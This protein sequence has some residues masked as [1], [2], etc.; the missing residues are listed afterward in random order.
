MVVMTACGPT[1]GDI[2]LPG[3]G[4]TGET[5]VAKAAFDD[6]LNLSQG[7]IVRI[8]GVASGRVQTVRVDDFRAIV[9]MKLHKEAQ[10][11][12][13]ATARLRYTT[14]LGELFVEITN[15]T[16][17]KLLADGGQLPVENASTAPTVEDSLAAASLLINGGGLGQLQTIAAELNK[18][19]GGREDT[20]HTLLRRTE[21]L[22]T[23]ANNSS[24][25][26]LRTLDA[27]AQVSK[28][29]EANESVIHEALTDMRPAVKVLRE[30][31]PGL[32]KLLAQV[33]EF[34]DTAN[35]VVGAT[36]EGLLSMLRQIVPILDEMLANSEVLGPSLSAL[37]TAS[38]VLD[39]IVVGDYINL[40]LTLQ[41]EQLRILGLGL[42]SFSGR[43]SAPAEAETGPSGREAGR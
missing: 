32:T 15:P 19:F 31:A 23:A 35:D 36:R 33:E 5:I 24:G 21:E 28:T 42:D 9:T 10:L 13:A 4:V 41:V 8:N 12:E 34:A 25:D 14:P 20:I 38:K 11:R 2:P 29:L 37:T 27:L 17:G 22:V 26:F 30:E 7:A 16:D 1:M 3:S 40:K 6:V 18:A 43:Q 39:K